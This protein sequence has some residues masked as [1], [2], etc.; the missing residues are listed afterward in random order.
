[1]IAS[2]DCPTLQEL[3]INQSRIAGGYGLLGMWTIDC[4]GSVTFLGQCIFFLQHN[5]TD[6]I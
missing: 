3:D 4:H 5:R 2:T 6:L 1:M